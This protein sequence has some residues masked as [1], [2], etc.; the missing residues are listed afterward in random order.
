MRY[1][2]HLLLGIIA[3]SLMGIGPFF[4]PVDQKA[5]ARSSY[6]LNCFQEGQLAGAGS[7]NH[8]T[9]RGQKFILTAYHVIQECDAVTLIEGNNEIF[10][11][12][13]VVYDELLDSS[14]DER[15]VELVLDILR[16]RV[17]KHNECIFVISHR[18]ES[19]KS[20]NG[21]IIFLEK[22]NGITRRVNFID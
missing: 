22:H 1:I 15:G 19:I 6:M 5:K 13:T 21:D 12:K 18:K 17:E 16:E 11:L 20:A 7:G 9:Y 4:A 8:F 14:L 10:E 2:K 3:I